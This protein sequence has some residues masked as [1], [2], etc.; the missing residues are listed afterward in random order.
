LWSGID[1]A[2]SPMMATLSRQQMHVY[3]LAKQDHGHLLSSIPIYTT[4]IVVVVVSCYNDV[5]MYINPIVVVV[6]SHYNH[7]P[8]YTNDNNKG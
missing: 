5:R 6:V 2:Y 4:P 3:P 8:V 7:V 1:P